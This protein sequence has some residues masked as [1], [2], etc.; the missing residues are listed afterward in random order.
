MKLI[1]LIKL[2]M[3]HLWRT[4]VQ[5]TYAWLAVAIILEFFWDSEILTQILTKN[6]T[7]LAYFFKTLFSLI[8]PSLSGAWCQLSRCCS[9]CSYI[10]RLYC[11]SGRSSITRT[12]LVWKEF[13]LIRIGTRAPL[14]GYSQKELSQFD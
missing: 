2:L 9:S 6:D 1:Q 8:I 10:V 14:Y 5:H 11:T 12:E 13:L 7:N 4:K 3:C